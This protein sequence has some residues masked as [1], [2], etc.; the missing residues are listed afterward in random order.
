MGTLSVQ[1]PS[2]SS[3]SLT[4]VFILLR[5]NA[6]QSR[7]IFSDPVGKNEDRMSLVPLHESDDRDLESG[8][9]GAGNSRIPPEWV[10]MVDEVQYEMSRVR[11]RLKEL[12]DNQQKHL[13][14]P[15]FN[16]DSSE[17]ERGIA[18][19]TQEITKML[20][21]C[22]RLVQHI[23][24]TSSPKRRGDAYLLKNVITSLLQAL[25]QLTAEFRVSQTGYLRQVQ[26]RDDSFQQYFEAFS[27]DSP[28]PSRSDGEKILSFNANHPR[29]FEIEIT[30]C[31]SN[32]VI[33]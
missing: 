9:G 24:Q 20:A 21:H 28:G 15:S 4:E 13:M 6:V 14:R 16:D 11:T 12:K 33:V 30:D 22:Q 5:N 31:V 25:Q 17:E 8:L 18:V 23:Q 26:S 7:H 32:C 29:I 1:P 3:R 19:A 27:A 2:G 10:N